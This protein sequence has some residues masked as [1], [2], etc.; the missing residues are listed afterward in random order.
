RREKPVKWPKGTCAA[1]SKCCARVLGWNGT[2]WNW[3][4]WRNVKFQKD[5]QC[6]VGVGIKGMGVTAEVGT[7]DGTFDAP[8]NDC[9]RGQCKWSANKGKVFVLWSQAGLHELEIVGE[10][11][12][13][14]NQQKMQGLQMRGVRV[15]DGDRCSATFQRVFDHEAAELD[16]DLYE[17]LGLQ[18]DADEADIK[19]VYRKLSIK[20]HPDK[21]PDEESKRKF[22]EVRDAYE[23]RRKRN[24]RDGGLF[25]PEGWRFCFFFWLPLRVSIDV[26][27]ISMNIWHLPNLRRSPIL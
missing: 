15:S 13:E 23:V 2:E 20:Y 8:T 6:A 18:D 21:N 19:K 1:Q 10:V 24:T 4:S 16:K 7:P 14:Q 25:G 12:T 27:R 9:H 26:S 17:I 5:D 22:A 11:P 3:N